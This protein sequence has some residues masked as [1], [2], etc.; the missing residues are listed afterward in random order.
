MKVNDLLNAAIETESS[1]LAHTLYAGLIDGKIEGHEEATPATYERI[2]LEKGFQL[3]KNNTLGLKNMKL[4]A[5]PVKNKEFEMF[6]AANEAEAK[7]LYYKSFR[8]DIKTVHEVS[9]GIDLSIYS[10][11]TKTHQTWREMR[12]T[13][14][15]LPAYVGTFT[16]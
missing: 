12:D 16:K 6:F 1:L 7:K 11:D 2:D 9:H 4:F 5:A 8:K 14:P 13:L 15:S 10:P 3:Y